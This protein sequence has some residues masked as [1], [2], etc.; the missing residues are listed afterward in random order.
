MKILLATL[1]CLALCVPVFADQ[2]TTVLTE[3]TT[4]GKAQVVLPYIDGSNS[5]E[6]EKQANVLIKK[7]AEDLAKKVNG[8][9]VTYKVM[10]NRPSVVS[11]LLEA[12]NGDK[13]AYQGLN[14]DLTTGKS[15]TVTD[16]FVDKQEVR[17]ILGS[18]DNV[19]FAEDG[20]YILQDEKVGYKTLVPYEK[21]I[22]YMR[23]GEAGRLLQIAKLTDS[24]TG[25]TLTLDKPGLV[26]LKLAGNPSTGYS[27]Y[28]DCASPDVHTVGSTF[29]IPSEADNRVGTPGIEIV[30]LAVTKAGTYNISMNY[31]RAWEKTSLQNFDFTV[32]VK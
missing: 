3:H 31:K 6:L 23:V 25:K 4:L 15:F 12:V 8:G 9:N 13:R 17:Q 27:W 10:L 16:F 2:K 21:L 20:L 24:A 32:I 1:L 14:I 28:A 22:S 26:A 30:F 5:V 11:L 7:T 29:T 18:Y 19:L